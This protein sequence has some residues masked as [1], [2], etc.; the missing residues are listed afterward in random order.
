MR[1]S[2]Q[3][4]LNFYPLNSFLQW[5]LWWDS[6]F[7]EIAHNLPFPGLNFFSNN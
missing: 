6:L 5:Q 2:N 4:A 7:E 3:S 1:D